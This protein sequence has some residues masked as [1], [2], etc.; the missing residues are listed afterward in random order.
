MDEVCGNA[1]GYSQKKC[2]TMA[3]E[4]KAAI[5]NEHFWNHYTNV[6]DYLAPIV[7]ALLDFDGKRPCIGKV[8]HI[9]RRLGKHVLDYKMSLFNWTCA[10]LN[11]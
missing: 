3:K 2:H 7:Y 6:R 5:L 10:K 1:T 4:V 11:H 9:M 8:L